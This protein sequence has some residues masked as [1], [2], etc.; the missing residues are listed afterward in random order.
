MIML[1]PKIIISTAVT[2]MGSYYSGSK[3]TTRAICP[4]IRCQDNQ[5]LRWVYSTRTRS[6]GLGG[7]GQA[8]RTLLVAIEL[9]CDA[10]W[11]R[12]DIVAGLRDEELKTTS[13]QTSCPPACLLFLCVPGN[14]KGHFWLVSGGMC[15]C[16]RAFGRPWPGCG[17]LSADC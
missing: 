5:G 11:N 3:K 4:V 1:P 13:P 15:Q 17:S 16:A 6:A 12:H 2:H 8:S 7:A 9:V 14:V 10:N